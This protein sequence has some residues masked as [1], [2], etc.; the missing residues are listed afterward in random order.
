MR[1]AVLSDVHGNLG[2][3]RAVLN[4]VQADA[5]IATIIC[6]GDL[7]GLGPQPNEVISLLR[8]VGAEAVMGNYDD[9]VAFNRLSSGVDF[10]DDT[11]EQL[12]RTALAWTRR[13][14]SPESLRYLRDLR[15][16]VRLLGIGGRFELK[17]D[18]PD[19][20]VSEFRRNFVMRGLLGSLATPARPRAPTRRILV[21]HAGPR[22]LN[23]FIRP[24]S[25]V[26]ILETISRQA[27]ADIL[28]TGHAGVGFVREAAGMTFVGVGSVS[29][30]RAAPGQADFAVVDVGEQLEVDFRTAA[31]DAEEHA[32]AINDAGLPAALAA[33]VDLTSL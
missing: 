19:E 8:D 1:F 16:Q 28:I 31:Y 21:T 25:A 22:A 9:A 26:S 29:G 18:Q 32:R 3:L 4:V 11:A 14:L 6:A 20:R 13:T 17:R 30:L 12:D 33:R 23:E 27:Q 5:E 24:D 2:A 10:P 7:V 15:R